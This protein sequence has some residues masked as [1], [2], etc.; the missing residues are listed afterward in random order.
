[1]SYL[2]WSE[3]RSGRLRF[4]ECQLFS[5]HFVDHRLAS[6]ADECPNHCFEFPIFRVLTLGCARSS[7]FVGCIFT[8]FP[9]VRASDLEG[10]VHQPSSS[11]RQRP[12]HAFRRV[13]VLRRC[14]FTALPRR[15]NAAP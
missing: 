1:M 9:K 6:G 8:I 12:W 14:V 11:G 5:R 13:T 3:W 7:Q 10:E 4:L 15:L 2:S